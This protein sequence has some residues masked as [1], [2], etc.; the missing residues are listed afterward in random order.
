MASNP[1]F[2]ALESVFEEE[3]SVPSLDH[4]PLTVRGAIRLL[5]TWSPGAGAGL[6]GRLQQIR[7]RV[8]T[9]A[10]ETQADLQPGRDDEI[11]GYLQEMLTVYEQMSAT[12][13]AAGRAVEAENGA[14]VDEETG[15]LQ[16]LLDQ[17]AHWDA[18]VRDWS[19][20]PVMRCLRCGRSDDPPSKV[21]GQCGLE[22]LYN[23]PSPPPRASR[24]L[25]LGPE[26]AAAFHAWSAVVDGEASLSSLWA[27][28]EELQSLLRRYVRMTQHELALGTAGEKTTQALTRIS[29]ATQESL[30]GVERLQAVGTNRRLAELQAGWATIF[31]NA[32]TIQESI[33][34]LVRLVGGPSAG[35]AVEAEDSLLIDFD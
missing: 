31:E 24:T 8:Q 2:S 4:E 22:L 10:R 13:E 35:A 15:T 26:Y 9:A 34:V 21:C 19:A 30:D 12:L 1:L 7:E 16:S 33:P 28:L 27:P 25:Q 6:V 20:R 11:Q 29:L 14:A 18:Q 23:D 5:Q 17:L 32:A 3:G